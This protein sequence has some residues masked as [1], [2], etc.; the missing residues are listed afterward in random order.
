MWLEAGQIG[1]TS[2]GQGACLGQAGS[3][4]PVREAGPVSP[5]HRLAPPAPACEGSPIWDSQIWLIIFYHVLLPVE[6]TG[7]SDLRE[8]E[9][10]NAMLVED[11][12]TV[13]D[14]G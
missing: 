1:K 6:A 3:W 12:A 4:H 2:G 10:R 13:P 8:R 11:L 9:V 14:S 7:T 5:G